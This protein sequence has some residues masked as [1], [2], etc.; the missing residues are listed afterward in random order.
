MVSCTK[1]EIEYS[2]SFIKTNL[3][4]GIKDTAEIVALKKIKLDS[5]DEGIPST[6]I[7]EISLLKGLNHMNIVKFA[8]NQSF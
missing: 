7:K 2:G 1:R 3:M 8:K 4:I 5:E 6:A